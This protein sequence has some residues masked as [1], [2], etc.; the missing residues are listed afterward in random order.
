MSNVHNLFELQFAN[1]VVKDV[2]KVLDIIDDI[3][4]KL[5]PYLMYKDVADVYGASVD[6]SIMLKLQ[7][8]AYSQVVK[9]KGKV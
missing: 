8:D 1:Q 6:A 3:Q 9:N 7:L 4:K 5:E 2:P